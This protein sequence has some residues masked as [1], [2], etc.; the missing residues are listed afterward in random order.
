MLLLKI[1]K[2]SLWCDIDFINIVIY[3]ALYVVLLKYWKFIY[4]LHS[5][6]L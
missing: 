4:E 5:L 1:N 2:G 6:A 3:K